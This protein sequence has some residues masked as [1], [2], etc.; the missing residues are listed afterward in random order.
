MLKKLEKD[1]FEIWGISTVFSDPNTAQI[2]Q[3]DVTFFRI[4]NNNF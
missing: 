2:L 3:V 1:G 4:T